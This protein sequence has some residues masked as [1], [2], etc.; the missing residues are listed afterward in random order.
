ME[1]PSSSLRVFASEC[2]LF[3]W[4]ACAG[5]GDGEGEEC[6]LGRPGWV[7]IR[8]CFLACERKRC[9][10]VQAAPSSPSG[11]VCIN[12]GTEPGD[13]AKAALHAGLS[14]CAPV[15]TSQAANSCAP[16]DTGRG[17]VCPEWVSLRVRAG[18]PGDADARRDCARLEC[19]CTTEK[20]SVKSRSV[21]LCCKLL[22]PGSSSVTS[23]VM[24]SI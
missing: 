5:G 21:R 15:T 20:R 6:S 19:S 8:E 17:V 3:R 11:I 16:G 4:Q 22:G 24:A 14:G 10:R 1:F 13:S 18:P 9:S 23:S 2:L 12:A 7:S